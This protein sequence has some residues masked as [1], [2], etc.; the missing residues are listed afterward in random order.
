MYDITWLV[1][2]LQEHRVNAEHPV[3]PLFDH[4]VQSFIKWYVEERTSVKSQ[5]LYRKTAYKK[6]KTTRLFHLQG[7]LRN[8]NSSN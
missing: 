5:T 1:Q 2:L 7:P 6:Q 4:N 3:E 8:Q